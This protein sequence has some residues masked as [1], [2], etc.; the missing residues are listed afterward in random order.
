MN[1][2][3]FVN[4]LF[5]S[6]NLQYGSQ[7]LQ[8]YFLGGNSNVPKCN[9]R[10]PNTCVQKHKSEKERYI[11]MMKVEIPITINEFESFISLIDIP[12]II[13]FITNFSS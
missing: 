1:E 12:H 13:T 11:H 5:A 3:V 6:V 2:T 4:F 10:L 8:E 9:K 7:F